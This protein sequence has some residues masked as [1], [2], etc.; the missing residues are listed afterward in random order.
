MS[1]FLIPTFSSFVRTWLQLDNFAKKT[2]GKHE[3]HGRPYV[4]SADQIRVRY[5][6][7]SAKEVVTSSALVCLLAG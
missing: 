5:V 4:V 6:I 1:R 7:T 3:A 2:F